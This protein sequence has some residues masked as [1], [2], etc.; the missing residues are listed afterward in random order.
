[1]PDSTESKISDYSRFSTNMID[2]LCNAKSLLIGVEKIVE[3]EKETDEISSAMRL[4]RMLKER[5]DSV[6]SA[7]DEGPGKYQPQ[8]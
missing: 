6:I 7:I 5:I 2:E 1:M 4:L 3:Q 8:Q